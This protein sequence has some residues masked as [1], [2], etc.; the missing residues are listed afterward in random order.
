MTLYPHP[1]IIPLNLCFIEQTDN[2]RIKQAF[3]EQ[4]QQQP[5]AGGLTAEPQG[6]GQVWGP[7]VGNITHRG[8]R[9]IP[10]G[11][12]HWPKEFN[13]LYGHL[14]ESNLRPKWGLLAFPRT[15][16]IKNSSRYSHNK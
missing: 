12:K 11:P 9:L 8:E 2:P 10:D 14:W 6:E 1:I 3:T 13:S 5:T 4:Q 7:D 16:E 15:G